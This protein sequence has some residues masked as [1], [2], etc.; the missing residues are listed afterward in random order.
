MGLAGGVRPHPRALVFD[1]DRCLIDP[2][3]AWRYCIE[4]AVALASGTRL[5]AAELVAE[6]HQRPWRHALGVL[7]D[8][9]DAVT[10]CAE[11]SQAMFERS[12]MKK[13]L[14]HEGVAMA[15]DALR[16]ESIELGAISRLPHALAIKQ[17]HSTGLDRFLAV[18]SA[19]PEGEP[20]RPRERFE[21]CL[22]F[23]E[24]EPAQSGFV[25]GE[26]PD[27][28]EISGAGTVCFRAAWAPL[29]SGDLHSSSERWPI[30][31]VPSESAAV[32][33]RR[34]AGRGS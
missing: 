4:E 30:I 3:N 33:V 29:P 28:S 16:A 6:Y 13:L 14:V 17:I 19:T 15:L 24:A 20:W 5:S 9:P 8:T 11:L 25:S 27:L 26:E 32:V 12:A 21:T 7:L 1:L 18:L 31:G 2:R 23:L 22:A 34:W 10:R